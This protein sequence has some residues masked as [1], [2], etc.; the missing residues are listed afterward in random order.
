MRADGHLGAPE[1]VCGVDE[2]HHD[3]FGALRRGRHNVQC[4]GRGQ[5]GQ[6]G[7]DDHVRG[8]RHSTTQLLSYTYSALAGITPTL[9]QFSVGT[10][11]IEVGNYS[12]GGMLQASVQDA[13]ASTSVANSI[14]INATSQSGIGKRGI[15]RFDADR[16]YRCFIISTVDS[17]AASVL[18]FDLE[19][20]KAVNLKSRSNRTFGAVQVGGHAVPLYCSVLRTQNQEMEPCSRSRQGRQDVR[21]DMCAHAQGRRRGRDAGG[22]IVVPD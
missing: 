5:H 4:L 8:V 10:A 9:L 1:G 12:G 19:E 6:W 14:S 15:L 17:S 16:N 22:P 18:G 20:S 13:F 2:G 11:S 7:D 21:S 3:V